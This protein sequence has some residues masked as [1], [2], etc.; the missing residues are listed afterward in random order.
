M[1][2]LIAFSLPALCVLPVE[3]LAEIFRY[4][5]DKSLLNAA[6]ASKYFMKICKG[7]PVLR[8]RIRKRIVEE[9]KIWREIVTNARMG[10]DVIREETS[11]PFA[12]NV[13]KVVEIRP[14]HFRRP[15][16]QETLK[17]VPFELGVVG[18]RRNGGGKLRVKKNHK[19][20]A[21]PY[22]AIRC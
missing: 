22:N 21:E 16:E 11:Q 9:K 4:L 6:L 1:F 7:D 8:R 10:V 18:S 19:V 20:R 17:A 13:K 2:S 15:A 12:R 3:M 14:L 5:D